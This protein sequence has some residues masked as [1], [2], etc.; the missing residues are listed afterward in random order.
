M[1]QKRSSY[2]FACNFMWW[3]LHVFYRPLEDIGI[4]EILERVD[5]FEDN[6]D[7]LALWFVDRGL[8]PEARFL[9]DGKLVTIFDLN[10]S[11][12][13]IA[14]NWVSYIEATSRNL[15]P[16]EQVRPYCLY[17]LEL[18]W[19]AAILATLDDFIYDL[20]VPDLLQSYLEVREQL[21]EKREWLSAEMKD[22][23]ENHIP[24]DQMSE[25]D[26]A[27]GEMNRH[28][29]EDWLSTVLTYAQ[30]YSSA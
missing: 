22:F 30:Q 13:H 8:N 21:L 12:D 14:A 10:G 20:G 25:L 4:E 9:K 28:L 17:Y 16:E 1:D 15:C 26:Q 11:Q 27:M 19:V 18:S 23:S 7:D 24:V 2:Y 6:F 3:V 29:V 5:E